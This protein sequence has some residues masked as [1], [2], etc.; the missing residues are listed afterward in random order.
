MFNRNKLVIVAGSVQCDNIDPYIP[1][2]SKL[3]RKLFKD[4]NE[5]YS[6]LGAVGRKTKLFGDNDTMSVEKLADN[7]KMNLLS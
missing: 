4:T 2:D 7:I 1:H 6:Y 3:I 5:L